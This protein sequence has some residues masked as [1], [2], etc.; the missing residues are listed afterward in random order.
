MPKGPKGEK[1]PQNLTMR[2]SMRQFTGPA[3]AF[4][5]KVANH[6]RVVALYAVWYN[7]VGIHKALRATPAMIIGMTGKLRSAGEIVRGG[8]T[9]DSTE[10]GS[11]AGDQGP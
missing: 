8:R 7:C 11:I 5:R 3:N 6:C 4:P 9:G 2:N 10:G 1:R